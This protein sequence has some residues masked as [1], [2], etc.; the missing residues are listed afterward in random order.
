V[1]QANQDITLLKEALVYRVTIR[2]AD[3][4]IHQFTHNPFSLAKYWL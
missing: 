1:G 2:P 3:K 4:K